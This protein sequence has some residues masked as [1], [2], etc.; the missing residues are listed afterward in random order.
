MDD[1][2]AA[3][4]RSALWNALQELTHGAG[5]ERK[6]LLDDLAGKLGEL[7][8]YWGVNLSVNPRENREQAL[9]R[10]RHAITSNLYSHF[11]SL[12]PPQGVP[13]N[14]YIHA[15]VVCFNIQGDKA[16]AILQ[17][18]NI[19]ERRN[20]LAEKG[21]PHLRVS[22]STS[23]RYVKRAISQIVDDIFDKLDK[24]TNLGSAAST[25]ITG[26]N[27]AE[28]TK[29][30]PKQGGAGFNHLYVPRDKVH[31]EFDR[32]RADAARLIVLHGQAGMGKT[33]L[34][35]EL[36]RRAYPDVQVPLIEV[37]GGQPDVTGIRAALRQF[38]IEVSDSIAGDPKL[39]LA[40]LLTDEHGP[41]VTILDG[42]E[43]ADDL[44]D[45]IPN[46]KGLVI[47]TCR[48][49]GGSPPGQACFI[50]VGQMETPEAVALVQK[51]LPSLADAEAELL[52]TSLE[53]YPLIMR[54]ACALIAQQRIPVGQFCESLSSDI[55]RFAGV[56]RTEN[57]QALS[58][59]LQQTLEAIDRAD[60][61]A[62]ELAFLV[63]YGHPFPFMS[64]NILWR[65]A[66]IYHNGKQPM[67]VT[68]LATT[69]DELFRFALLDPLQ[70][71]DDSLGSTVSMHPLTRLILC[72]LDAN[73]QWGGKR[74]PVKT[75]L[76]RRLADMCAQQISV[77]RREESYEP[78][79]IRKHPAEL[80]WLVTLTTVLLGEV[81]I[82][83]KPEQA[84]DGFTAEDRD[85]CTRVLSTTIP[86]AQDAARGV[87]DVPPHYL[88]WREALRWQDKP[89]TT[90]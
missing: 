89:S 27:Y 19:T 55:G 26:N 77:R 25:T 59:V 48:D 43:S 70:L 76:A 29:L 68:Q 57:R 50:P 65:Y 5:I 10:V 42:L 21:P 74:P 6:D 22:V 45:L 85:Y 3:E 58:L 60:P 2:D 72:E 79:V 32:I 41:T 13:R 73:T 47:A 52:A 8:H 37:Q 30:T 31:T 1:R 35:R 67:P 4:S 82:D 87:W 38:N 81:L 15:L 51:R 56:T 11:K 64:Q 24:P 90:G 63:A 46:A 66:S 40:V 20:W 33:W 80:V 9:Q 28:P 71:L 18:A 39:C 16:H 36:A 17:D 86:I 61:A 53:R 84:A 69:L 49:T 62:F 34:A 7:R 88:A 83:G 23:Q 75:L 44:R 78:F 12:K 14:E 54:Y